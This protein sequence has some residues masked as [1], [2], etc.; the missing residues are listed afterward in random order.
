MAVLAVIPARAGS[1][2]V[3]G[4]NWREIADGLSLVRHAEICA[5]ESGVC[6]RVAV[7]TDDPEYV[8][9]PGV[10]YWAEPDLLAGDGADISDAVAWAVSS[11]FPFYDYIVTLQPAVL[12]RSPAIVRS[13]VRLVIDQ[14][15]EGGITVAHT[16]PWHWTIPQ[17]FTA[18]NGWF[19]G[20]YPRS[21]IAGRNFV[22][23]NA[24]QVASRRAV[25]DGKRWGLPLILG[26]LPAWAAS[27]DI[28]TEEDLELARILWPFASEQ[29]ERLT[30][31]AHR[32]ETLNG[33]SQW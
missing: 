5:L 14:G 19:P 24:V 2:R 30:L 7:L 6:D 23:I 29:L 18:T 27:L 1:K 10:E 25:M 28:D 20:P 12:A 3:V 13:L 31:H 33:I 9:M 22:E 8:P 4:K 26:E 11:K 32:V 17:S 21:Q 15:A 16:A